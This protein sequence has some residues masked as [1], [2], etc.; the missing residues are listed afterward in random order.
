MK[1]ER[2]KDRGMEGRGE[3]GKGAEREGRKGRG[4]DGWREGGVMEGR[5]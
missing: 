5:V 4:I 2:R 1:G 3:G